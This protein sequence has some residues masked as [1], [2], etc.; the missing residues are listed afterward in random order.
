MDVKF[1]FFQMLNCSL[2]KKVFKDISVERVSA[3]EWKELYHLSKSQGVTAVMFDVLSEAIEKKT[4]HT[5][6]PRELILQWYSH[7]MSIEKQMRMIKSH[8]E[9]FAKLMAENG[10]TTCV[11]KGVALS[12]YYPNPLHREF[13]DLDC[14]LLEKNTTNDKWMSAYEKGNAIAEAQK[15]NVSRSLY[16]HSRFRY[17]RLTIE[18]HQFNLS[19]RGSKKAKELERYLRNILN[20]QNAHVIDFEQSPF[21]YPPADYNA[22]FLTSHGIHHFLSEGIKIRQALDWAIFLNAEYKRVNWKVFWTWCDKMHYTRF[23]ECLNWICEKKMGLNENIIQTVMNGRTENEDLE[24]LANRV[25]D[26]IFTA[27]SIF[28][29][30]YS[31]FWMRML[32]VRNFFLSAWKYKHIAQKNFLIDLL[33]RLSAMV[34]DRNPRI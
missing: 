10:L 12:H 22:L 20:E 8:S 1:L 16:K 7:T 6:P 17:K 30:G 28:N 9:E 31:V 5:K 26:D 11:L 25:F 34:W 24:Y 19:V 21:L 23:V 32:V 3:E 4:I 33:F 14:L 18:N 29:K 2:N 27:N 15:I 13:G